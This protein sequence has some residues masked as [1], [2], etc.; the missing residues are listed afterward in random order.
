MLFHLRPS[1]L[2]ALLI[3]LGAYATDTAP[4]QQETTQQSP[5]P[6]ITKPLLFNTPEADQILS[7]LQFF[8]TNNPWNEDISQ[9]P[10]ATNS[11]RMIAGMHTRQSLGYR[12][13]MSFV[14]VPPN[15]P[16]VPVKIKAHP[17][18]SD[19]G[20]YPIPDQAPIE[21]WPAGIRASGERITLEALQQSGDGD[22][23][24]L[25]LDPCAMKLY[26]FYRMFKGAKGWEADQA[27]V[28]DLRS[29]KPRPKNWASADS[30]GLPIIPA[31]VR[32]DECERGMVNHAMRFT[33]FLTR[34]AYVYPATH[35][36]SAP[37]DPALPR[38]GERFRLRQNFDERGFSPHAQ[39]IL[40]GLKKYGMF[41]AD[42][43]IDW[44]ISVTPDE[45]FKGL[46]DLQRVRP[47]DFEVIVPSEP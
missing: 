9:R 44:M 1:F 38:M 23:H 20:P 21:G 33:V 19:P 14:I 3:P 6:A 28:F 42:N 7:H 8:P 39:A 31:T 26:E 24:L 45:R 18:E 30:A 17:A 25:V 13:D 40:K 15:Q 32:F 41:V 27:S 22:H 16:R 10:V 5:F 37:S 4:A 34:R 46:D 2:L 29:N 47:E 36:A 12:F 11:A 43:G 35:F